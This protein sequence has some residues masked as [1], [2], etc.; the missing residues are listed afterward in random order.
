[1]SGH[2]FIIDGDL[3][4]I[5]C[6]AILIPTDYRL[7][8]EDH[9]I[10][11]LERE[12]HQDQLAEF[13]K[14]L[15]GSWGGRN[16]IKLKRI[17]NHPQVWLGNIGKDGNESTYSDFADEIEQFITMATAEYHQHGDINRIYEWP[18]PRLALPVV[19]S[20]QGG[21]A[22]KKGDLILG[23]VETLGPM[24]RRPELDADII[25]VTHGERPYAAAQ[26]ARRM[27]VGGAD[28]NAL[29]RHWQFEN[30]PEAIDLI[31]NAQ[32]LATEAITS[33]LVLFLGAGVSAGAGLPIWK[34][35]LQEIAQVAGFEHLDRL[36]EVDERDQATILQGRLALQ[37][38][39]IGDLVAA[40]LNSH[41]YSLAHGL[42]A[43]LPS[44]EAVTTNYDKLFEAAWEST[45]RPISTLPEHAAQSNER[46][47]MKLHG[48]V[49]KSD[50]IVMTRSDYLDMPMHHAALLGLVQGLLM[51]RHMVFVGYGMKDEDFHE[52]I[53]EVRRAQ[54]DAVVQGPIGT[55]LT[56]KEDPL[57]SELWMKDLYVLPMTVDSDDKDAARQLE[58][59]LDLVGYLSTTSA[60]F[61]LD[62][63]YDAVLTKEE[64]KLRAELSNL[65]STVKGADTETVAGKVLRFLEEELGADPEE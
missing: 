5:S 36:E 56:L 40:R 16:M 47:L 53:H 51:M 46:W 20:D 64:R 54:G 34:S 63:T 62:E 59:F 44:R 18:K 24:A 45:G 6:D 48:C 65:L 23:L 28:E 50:G 27:I 31:S 42:L 41:F 12:G 2:L 13:R 17:D 19:G 11:L 43:S 8:I 58:I 35:L 7:S 38:K 49:T 29:L 14:D 15:A 4:Q 22:N 30:K 21:G 52:L 25:L 37:G 3:T 26:R 33:Q 39:K 61:F 57:N 32:R 55:V 60:A 1:M 9:W 10:S